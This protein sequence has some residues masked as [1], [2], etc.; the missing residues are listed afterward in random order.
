MEEIA[1]KTEGCS[2]ADLESLLNESGYESIRKG[3]N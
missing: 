2:G 3:M 1:K